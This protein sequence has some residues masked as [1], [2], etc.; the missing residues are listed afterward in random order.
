MVCGFLI[1]KSRIILLLIVSTILF[2]EI[3]SIV[4]VPNQMSAAAKDSSQRSRNINIKEAD[5]NL[6]FNEIK[7]IPYNERSMNCKHKSE[8]FAEYLK[9]IGA[10]EIYIVVVQHDSGKYSHEFVEWNGHY[11]DACCS[12][13]SYKIPKEEYIKKLTRI[14]F[15]GIVLTSQY[16]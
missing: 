7:N 3:F 5:I 2:L 10:D 4:A 8:L 16:V 6:K 11:Y 12:D 15:T 9:S 14:G 1:K 13:T